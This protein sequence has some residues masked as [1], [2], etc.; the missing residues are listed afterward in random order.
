MS[1]LVIFCW[2][3]LHKVEGDCAVA[4]LPMA[5]WEPGANASRTKFFEYPIAST[6]EDVEA[7][8]LQF[9]TLNR[10]NPLE[11]SAAALVAQWR[12][13]DHEAWLSRCRDIKEWVVL[14]SHLPKTGGTGL[15][16]A[17]RKVT[18]L[19]GPGR[20]CARRRYC[21]PKQTFGEIGLEGWPPEPGDLDI[22]VNDAIALARA[23]AERV[24]FHSHFHD[25]ARSPK[26]FSVVRDPV[27]RA[28]SAYYHL[29]NVSSGAL[30]SLGVRDPEACASKRC[31]DVVGSSFPATGLLRIT[32]AA[33]SVVTCPAS[34]R[35]PLQ[36]TA[37][38][39]QGD[40]LI[41]C[42]TPLDAVKTANDER[43]WD[44]PAAILRKVRLAVGNNLASRWFQCHVRRNLDWRFHNGSSADL[45]DPVV[46]DLSTS[47][48]CRDDEFE[49]VGLTERLTESA[50]L[51]ECRFGNH[52]KGLTRAI[53]SS[54]RENSRRYPAPS[55]DLT[56]YLVD[57]NLHDVRLYRRLSAR[58]DDDLRANADCVSRLLNDV[59][60]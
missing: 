16:R 11:A 55:D 26:V 52:L 12:T 18:V 20:P 13:V 30:E 51:L 19:T 15:Q 21:A 45:P 59:T 60:R 34:D 2:V 46:W 25:A 22:E 43:P 4:G 27:A 37:T 14:F 41:D 23:R 47:E 17:L 1:A 3:L 44:T 6:T 29:A 50:A 31:L 56:T 28:L 5:I 24:V 9:A 58:F 38:N 7:L 40:L 33:D 53:M 10:L 32:S 8:A 35:A 39:V 42:G 54:P 57:H 36:A 48:E 49:V